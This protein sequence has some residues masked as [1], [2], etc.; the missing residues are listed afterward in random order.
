MKNSI[1]ISPHILVILRSVLQA[2]L[3]AATKILLYG[4]RAKGTAKKYSDI[5]LAID[6]GDVIPI[7]QF[8]ALISDLEESDIP[9]KV[10]IV[11]LHTIDESF[12]ERIMIEGV[13][14]FSTLGGGKI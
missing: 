8:T 5:D 7:S 9:Y 4:S 13:E 1:D 12:R 14:L 6:T 10:D 2:H 11:D 3:P